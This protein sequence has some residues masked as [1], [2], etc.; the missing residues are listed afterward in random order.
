M[1][2]YTTKAIVLNRVDYGEADR[3]ITMLTPDQGKI[4]VLARGVRK[5]K[6]K[7]AGGIELFSVNEV[8]VLAGRGEVHTLIS[9]RLS[10]Y[11]DQI[12]KDLERTTAGYEFIKIMNRATEDNPEPAYFELLKGSLAALNEAT[13]NLGLVQVWFQAQLLRLAGHT[14]NLK[15]DEEGKKLEAT[16]SYLF[17]FDTM[18]FHKNGQDDNSFDANS[19]KF[20]RLIF[21][22][23]PP[24][25]LQKVKGVGRL[26]S[27]CRPLVQ[28]MLNTYVR[29]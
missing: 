27:A 26:A 25:A 17:N 8:T 19:I 23:N 15:T 18:N 6:S 29:L 4:S 10:K 16:A 5:P 14:P 13:I 22:D 28:S 21:S 12:V 2:Q 9:A 20:L 11:Y 1:K 7:L 3:I 24:K